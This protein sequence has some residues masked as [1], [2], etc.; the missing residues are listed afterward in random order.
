MAQPF[1]GNATPVQEGRRDIRAIDA[2]PRRRSDK[3]VRRSPAE[4]RNSRNSGTAINVNL[5]DAYTP[6]Q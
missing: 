4:R 3:K 6:R 1:G 2:V 5:H